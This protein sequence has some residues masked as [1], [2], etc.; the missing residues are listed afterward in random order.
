M[1]VLDT[2]HVSLLERDSPDGHRL[3]LRLSAL[4]ADARTTTIVTYEEQTRGWMAYMARAK[5]LVDEIEAYGR[6]KIHLRNYRNIVVL[7]FDEHAAIEYQRL[8]R[9]KVR[10]GTKDLK[11]AAIVLANNSMLLSRNLSDFRKVPGLKVEDWTVAS[12]N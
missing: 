9:S 1:V 7:D 3:R 2:D 12:E 8:R 6:L 4:G 10:I 5:T 11:I